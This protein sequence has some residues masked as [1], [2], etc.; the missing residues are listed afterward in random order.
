M[1]RTERLVL[2]P[3][4]PDLDAESMHRGYADVDAIRWW[5]HPAP[6]SPE[7][8]HRRLV[9]LAASPGQLAICI[10]TRAVRFSSPAT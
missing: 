5:H 8:T 4:D 10:T 7:E 2:R 3:L 6:D 1:L 9:D